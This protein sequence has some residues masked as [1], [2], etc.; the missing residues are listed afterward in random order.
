MVGSRIVVATLNC[1]T[2]LFLSRTVNRHLPHHQSLRVAAV[3]LPVI[4]CGLLGIAKSG[5]SSSGL[6][7]MIRLPTPFVLRASHDVN[8]ALAQF[9]GHE[10]I[11]EQS[12][13]ENDIA[14]L[15]GIVHL[16]EEIRFTGSLALVRSDRQIVASAGCQGEQHRDPG[17]PENLN[18]G[19][20]WAAADTSV[21]FRACL[22]SRRSNRRR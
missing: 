2:R 19:L 4:P 21:D 3:L 17:Q 12:I 9:P 7:C 1:L 16:S 15:E 13:P 11:V 20:A 22:A 10:V 5:M 8:V 6:L 14:G 18:Q